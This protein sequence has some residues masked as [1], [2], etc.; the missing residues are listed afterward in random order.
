MKVWWCTVLQ[1]LSSLKFNT[2]W[3]EYTSLA[4]N[5]LL[6]FRPNVAL[7]HSLISLLILGVL[8]HWFFRWYFGTW[9]FYDIL[10]HDV[11]MIFWNMMLLWYFGTWCSYDILKHDASMIFWNMKLLWYFETWCVFS[12]CDTCMFTQDCH[13]DNVIS[14]Y[15]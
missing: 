3:I 2:F 4:T 13:V 11:P 14:R 15:K 1:I 5:F 9:C 10:E 8:K 7:T 12:M 6:I